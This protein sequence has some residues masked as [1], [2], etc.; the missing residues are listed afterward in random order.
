M[1]ELN[2]LKSMLSG[3]RIERNMLIRRTNKTEEDKNDLKIDELQIKALESAISA[4]SA[5]GEYIKKS[6]LL[7]KT[8]RRNS[9]WNEVTNSEGKGLEEIVNDL[10][11]YSFPEELSEDGTLTVH[12]SDGSKVNRVFVMGDNIFGGLYYPD[13]AEDNTMEWI[14]AKV[15]K[16]FP[17]NDYKCSKCGN[18]LNFDGVN[19]GRG[20]ANFCPNCGRKAV[21]K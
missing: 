20:D 9:I 21:Q 14:S 12:V 16:L 5:D 19:C 17:S 13:S 7:G 8:V 4:L 2:V 3:I 6:E 11:T 10:P 15:G 18:I 1:N